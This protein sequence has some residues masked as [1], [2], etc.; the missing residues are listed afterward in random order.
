MK[1][2]NTRGRFVA[3]ITGAFSIMIGLIYLMLI[4]ILDLRG[5]EMLP[6]P[7]EAFGEVVIYALNY[8]L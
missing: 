4:T 8:F 6:P 5:S 2:E 1:Q 7:P 3:I